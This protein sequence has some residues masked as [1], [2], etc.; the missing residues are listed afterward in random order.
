MKTLDTF[1]QDYLGKTKGY[2]DDTQY[3]GECLLSL[4]I[5]YNKIMP[6]GIYKR[7]K[8][9][10]RI[11]DEAMKKTRGRIVSAD[12][13][14]RIGDAQRGEKHWNWK[15]ENVK[16]RRLHG[17]LVLTYGKANHC[18]ECRD[19]HAKVYD[20]ANISGEYK[21]DPSDYKQLCRKCHIKFDETPSK[22]QLRK[23]CLDMG[24]QEVKV[25]QLGLDGNLIKY[26]PSLKN[27]SKEVGIAYQGI[28]ACIKGINRTSGG[29][30][31]RLA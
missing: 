1:I 17:W 19:K 28:S 10:Y 3:S 15:G 5:I 18:E 16:Y 12:V 30:L 22:K 2:P 6:S 25:A 8:E 26:F 21:R 31:W 14:K 9:W 29:Y 13:R 7:T 27:A 4:K 20:W 24:R 11:H 23:K